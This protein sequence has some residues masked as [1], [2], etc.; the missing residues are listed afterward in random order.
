MLFLALLCSSI[1]R[2]QDPPHPN[3]LPPGEGAGLGKTVVSVAYTTDGLVNNNEVSSLIEIKPGAPLTDDA[4]GATIRNLF[5]TRQFSDIRIEVEDAPGGAAVTVVLFRAYRVSPLKFSGSPVLSLELRRIVPFAEGTTFQEAAVALGAA[6]IKRRLAEEGYIQAQ[7]TPEVS[8]DKRTFNARV[9]YRVKAGKPAKV[10]ALFFDGETAPY[11]VAA[12]GKIAH[13]KPGDRYRESKAKADA[14]R[15]TA[16]L[17]K[18]S[19]LKGLVD[20]IAAQ[21]TE[22]GRV[23][24]VYRISV[25]PEVRFETVGIKAKTVK[26]EISAHRG[27]GLR[28]APSSVRRAKRKDLRGPGYRQ[29]GLRHQDDAGSAHRHGDGGRRAEF[30]IPRRS[31]SP[32]TSQSGQDLLSLMVTEGFDPAAEASWTR[33]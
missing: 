2:A 9:L 17:H 21:P 13:M 12:L 10:A 24:P 15:L 3:P 16:Y 6:A 8:Y 28:R 20:L 4:T 18:Q 11:T 7:V 23:M 14:T 27:A 25:G 31:P 19:R 29:G 30:A 22:D 5:A 32:A 26:N 1:A 33:T